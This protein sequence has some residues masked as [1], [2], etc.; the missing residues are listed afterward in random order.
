MANYKQYLYTKGTALDGEFS[1]APAFGKIRP[2]KHH[3]FWKSGLRWYGIPLTDLQ[4]IYRR[5]E[6]VFGKLCCGGR[7]FII[8]WLVLVLHDGSELALHIGDDVQKQ[9]EAL[10]QHLKD[11][12]PQIQ[13]GKVYD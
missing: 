8:E 4:R 13:Y 5:V 1:A 9:A 10:L 12:H 3:L 6:P 11:V 7:S 2:G